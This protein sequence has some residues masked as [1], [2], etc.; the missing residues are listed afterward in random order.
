MVWPD[1]ALID[2]LQKSQISQQPKG[3]VN[4]EKEVFKIKL[5]C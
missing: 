5:L 3:F 2:G 1:P 4:P